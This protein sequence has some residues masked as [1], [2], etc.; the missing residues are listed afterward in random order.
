MT[1]P[2]RALPL[3]LLRGF[4]AFWWDFLVGD[5]PELFIAAVVTV[6]VV[7][8]LRGAGQENAA[9]GVALPL[10]AIAALTVSIRRAQRASRRK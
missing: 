10:L 7:A 9:A 8:L 2:R 4:A 6:L 3:R 1:S 5:T